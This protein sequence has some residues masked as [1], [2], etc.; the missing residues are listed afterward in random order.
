M[1]GHSELQIAIN[2]A[3]QLKRERNQIALDLGRARM[4]LATARQ[5]VREERLEIN[6]LRVQLERLDRSRL[7][8]LESV[9][10]ENELLRQQLFDLSSVRSRRLGLEPREHPATLPLSPFLMEDT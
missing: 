6:L 3:A 7:R 9:N 4:I 10:Q 1:S 2:E 8:E 5:L